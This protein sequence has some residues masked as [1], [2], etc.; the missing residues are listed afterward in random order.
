MN[1]GW[2]IGPRRQAAIC[3]LLLLGPVSL[4]A[5][6]VQVGEVVYG[7]ATP[8]ATAAEPS[9][10]RLSFEMER[11]GP[12]LRTIWRGADGVVL[13]MDELEAAN[14]TLTRYRFARLNIDQWVRVTRDGKVLRVEHSERGRVRSS[15]LRASP[16]TIVGPM[17][18]LTAEHRLAD[19]IAGE[20]L[21]I[22]YAVPEQLA[23]YEF[24][25]AQSES[26]RGGMREITVTAN[27][28]L[29][30]QF[31]NPVLFYFAGQGEFAGM[32]GRALPVGGTPGHPQP[33]EVDAVV[34]NRESRTCSAVPRADDWFR[35]NATE[36]AM[37]STR[38]MWRAAGR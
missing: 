33:L 28:W 35:P 9:L 1:R 25:I 17:M 34:R 37:S 6:G 27:S 13:A 22:S 29:V 19:L 23:V 4:H 11:C 8:I 7:S 10:S 15:V 30:R 38:R 26:M 20:P 3:V 2:P 16:D 36:L 24:T 5:A 18:A 21:T 12:F 31:A 32:R 14:G